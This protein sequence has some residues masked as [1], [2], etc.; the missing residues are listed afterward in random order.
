M[1][2]ID[3]LHLLTKDDIAT[4][5]KNSDLRMFLGKCLQRFLSYVEVR[6]R[7]LDTQGKFFFDWQFHQ[8]RHLSLKWLYI[9]SGARKSQLKNA[10]AIICRIRRRSVMSK[11]A[12]YQS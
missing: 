11:S 9:P 4:I 8:I 12:M 5:H 10:R 1:P 2:T 6:C 3:R 7:F